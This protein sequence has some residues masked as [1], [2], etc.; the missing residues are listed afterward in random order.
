MTYPAIPTPICGYCGRTYAASAC[1]CRD[2]SR[3]RQNRLA[4]FGTRAAAQ[5]Q[6]VA[7]PRASHA[8]PARR[9]LFRRD[10]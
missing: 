9:G 5:R 7:D 10:A 6:G 8:G 4:E 1:L 3:A 2:A